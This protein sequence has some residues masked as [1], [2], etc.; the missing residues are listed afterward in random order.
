MHGAADEG[1]IQRS[2]AVDS[3]IAAEPDKGSVD[4]GGWAHGTCRPDA[5]KIVQIRQG[6]VSKL[7]K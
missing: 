4:L 6:R 3:Q 7:L 5:T 1:L 2:M